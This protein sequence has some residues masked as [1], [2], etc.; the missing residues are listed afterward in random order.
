MSANRHARMLRL[1]GTVL[2][3]FMIVSLLA[4]GTFLTFV[5]AHGV[6]LLEAL[7]TQ[8]I[9][10]ATSSFGPVAWNGLLR[11]EG[12][13]GD[14]SV[15]WSTET[16]PNLSD[17]SLDGP[18]V[19]RDIGFAT[20]PYYVVK[21]KGLCAELRVVPAL[22]PLLEAERLVDR[23][24]AGERSMPIRSR[25]R[26]YAQAISDL[27]YRFIEAIPRNIPG[28]WEERQ[29]A[30]FLVLLPL[31]VIQAGLQHLWVP[32]WALL[33]SDPGGFTVSWLIV[34]G[35]VIAFGVSLRQRAR[36]IEKRPA[37]P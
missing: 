8:G 26:Y 14:A 11:R 21:G 32:L 3:A 16:W 25:L 31:A 35:G 29:F 18:R 7:S 34:V 23:L 20:H 27:D 17:V 9:E 13:W 30:M 24:I 12:D 37:P 1:A 10:I 5:N 22:V 33:P 15:I 36:R 4:S 2:I 6:D 28:W 19:F